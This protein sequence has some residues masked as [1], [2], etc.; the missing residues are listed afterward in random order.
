MLKMTNF[1]FQS[2]VVGATT[3]EDD[4]T[5]K[6]ELFLNSTLIKT[7]FCQSPVES[8]K[9]TQTNKTKCL[10]QYAYKLKYSGY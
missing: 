1:F 9:N 7:V 6:R 4:G 10:K 5:C 8:R 3:L 2:M